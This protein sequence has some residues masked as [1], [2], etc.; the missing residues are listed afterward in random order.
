[1][2]SPVSINKGMSYIA[3]LRVFAQSSIWHFRLS[4]PSV[5]V[6]KLLKYNFHLPIKGSLIYGFVYVSCQMD[7]SKYLPFPSS[8]RVTKVSLEL[9]HFYLWTSHVSSLND[10]RYYV[11]FINNY[12]WFS[13]IYPLHRKLVTTFTY[14]VKFKCIAE[15]YLNSKIK[16]LQ[17]DGGGE[18]ISNDF[19]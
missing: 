14:F 13:W 15:N 17:T 19:R 6:L 3:F 8:T 2:K 12:T 11:I 16:S 9:V 1:M 4:H 7:K 18:F 10:Y 5:Q